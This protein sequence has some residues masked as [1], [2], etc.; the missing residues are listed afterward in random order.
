M[1]FFNLALAALPM[2]C[3]VNVRANSTPVSSSL[4]TPTPASSS[5]NICE[6]PHTFIPLSSGR[7]TPV[8]SSVRASSVATSAAPANTLIGGGNTEPYCPPK[9]DIPNGFIP[10]GGTSR[11]ASSP[12]SKPSTP[13]ATGTAS[14][15]AGANGDGKSSTKATGGS[16]TVPTQTSG[17][18]AI[19]DL[20]LSTS[21]YTATQTYTITKCPPEVTNCPVGSVTT[22]TVT[23][24]T[25]YCPAIS[26]PLTYTV[27]TTVACKSCQGG[28]QTTPVTVTI[29]PAPSSSKPGSTT[30]LGGN[31]PVAP[32]SVPGALS[33]SSGANR[34][35]SNGTFT[36][37]QPS[38]NATATGNRP[39]ASGPTSG[40]ASWGVQGLFTIAAGA[41]VAVLL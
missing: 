10:I 29:V 16:G 20:P 32:S 37:A 26:S 34:P 13:S 18:P 8:S 7:A 38:A 27:T 6:G 4:A 11:P 31:S 22:A 3:A 14:T 40:A 15:S 2:A 21:T 9:D 5:I 35:G 12:T 28:Q 33:P 19:T 30:T 1:K 25:T 23:Q 24:Y 41:L 36:S 17:K 39:A